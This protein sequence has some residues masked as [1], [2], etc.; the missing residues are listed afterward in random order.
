MD[1]FKRLLSLF[2]VCLL[3][4]AAFAHAD[5][6]ENFSLTV[7]HCTGGCAVTSPYSFGTIQ[8]DQV[9]TGTSA[10][11][12]VTETLA[13]GNAFVGTGAGDSLDFSITN[14]DTVTI[15]RSHHGLWLQRRLNS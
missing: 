9:G 6:I 1:M 13:S 11:V 7:D 8:L 14:P 3:A 5:I 10:Y 15:Q 12:I 2:A 4:S